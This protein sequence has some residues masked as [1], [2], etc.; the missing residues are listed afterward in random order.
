M[1]ARKSGRGRDQKSVAQAPATAGGP[2]DPPLWRLRFSPR[3][4]REDLSEIGDAAFALAKEAITKK[5]RQHP[6]QYGVPLRAPLTGM[7]KLSVSHVRIVY[8]VDEN[9]REVRV[10]MLGARRDIWDHDQ[11]EILERAQELA[12]AITHEQKTAA[13]Q[14]KPPKR[15][16]KV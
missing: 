11:P 5:L 1:S 3:I 2:T 7:R 16:P 12:N 10:Y 4:V 8:K 15:A 13:A 14:S 9:L 6:D